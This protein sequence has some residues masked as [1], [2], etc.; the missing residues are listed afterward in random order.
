VYTAPRKT[1]YRGGVDAREERVGLNEALFREVN[2]RVAEV[3]RG[4]GPLP[5][6]GFV[7]ECGSVECTERVTLPL[8]E[9]EGV[10]KVSTYFLVKPGHEI[11]DVETVIEARNGY[12]IVA[13]HTGAADV[14]IATDPRS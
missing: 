5:D 8:D 3:N 6:A 10:R 7:C 4:F 1:D 13:K 14:A 2:E 12:V 11:P 9:Y